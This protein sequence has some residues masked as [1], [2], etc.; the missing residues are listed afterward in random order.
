MQRIQIFCDLIVRGGNPM[1][2]ASIIELYWQ[3]A[4]RAIAETDAVYGRF[5][6]R[7]AHNILFDPQDSEE[8]VND[9]WL[10]AWNAMPPHRPSS[11]KMF[12][13]KLTRRISVSRL[14]RNTAAKRGGGEAELALDELAECVSAPGGVERELEARELEAALSRFVR[15]LPETER[16]LFI[17]RYWLV[18]PVN[19]LAA[20]LGMKPGTARS[21]LSRTRKSLKAYLCKEELC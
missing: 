3:R 4:E 2:D 12:L 11:L 8:S 13:G 18:L 16:M 7:I 10:A 20:R 14:R 19:E 5:C 15:S 6:Y 21:T 17:G 1:D 9:T